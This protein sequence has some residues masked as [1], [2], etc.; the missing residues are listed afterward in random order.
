[1][2]SRNNSFASTDGSIS[3]KSSAKNA[4]NI[5]SENSSTNSYSIS[6]LVK[7][8]RLIYR[9]NSVLSVNLDE[10]DEFERRN[11]LKILLQ[12]IKCKLVDDFQWL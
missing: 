6:P 5:S 3:I 10:A 4:K 8:E 2:T 7:L 1:M 12:V 11:H 9:L